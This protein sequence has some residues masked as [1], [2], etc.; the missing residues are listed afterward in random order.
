MFKMSLKLLKYMYVW[1]FSY[2]YQPHTTIIRQQFFKGIYCTV[3]L[4]KYIVLIKECLCCYYCHMLSVCH[5]TNNFTPYWV[6]RI[7]STFALTVIQFTISQLL[8][9]AVSQLHLLLESLPF[10]R[11]NW[12]R[13][14]WTS[15]S[16][17]AAIPS[18]G[19]SDFT[20]HTHT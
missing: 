8:P 11:Y 17:A 1:Y 6:E 2:M 14:C 19:L 13:R 7:Y 10:T 20:I 4:V 18:T 15:L 9:S 16:S 12:I 5:E 3:H